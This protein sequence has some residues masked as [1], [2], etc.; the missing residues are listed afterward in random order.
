MENNPEYIQNA[1]D[2]GYDVEVDVWGTKYGAWYLGHDEKNILL[3]LSFYD[4]TD[5]GVTQRN[6]VILSYGRR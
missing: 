1:L 2:L 3:M 5:Y 6:Q 4:K